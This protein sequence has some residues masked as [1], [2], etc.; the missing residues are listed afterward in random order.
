MP[1]ITDTFIGVNNVVCPKCNGTEVMPDPSNPNEM[2][3][4]DYCDGTG[5]VSVAKGNAYSGN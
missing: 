4:C 1:R 5:R 2:I 3:D